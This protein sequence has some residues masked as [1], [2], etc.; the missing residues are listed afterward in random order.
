M[1]MK[2]PSMTSGINTHITMN[3]VPMNNVTMSSLTTTTTTCS[4]TTTTTTAA[5]SAAIS[6]VVN[7]QQFYTP[8]K[9]PVKD[10]PYISKTTPV[11]QQ[12]PGGF[13]PKHADKCA[14]KFAGNNP[15]LT[16]VYTMLGQ[17]TEQNKNILFEVKKIPTLVKS[18]ES[19]KKEMNSR[20]ANLSQRVLVNENEITATK[21][22][23]HNKGLAIDN[24]KHNIN[25]LKEDNKKISEG[26]SNLDA[27]MNEMGDKTVSYDCGMDDD[28]PLKI[29]VDNIKATQGEL[30]SRLGVLEGNG[31][32][33]E[34]LKKKQTNI[35]T[36]LDTLE[37][38]GTGGDSIPADIEQRLAH[39]ENPPKDRINIPADFEHR[40]A[41]L[42]KASKD[43]TTLNHVST[44]GVASNNND[45]NEKKNEEERLKKKLVSFKDAVVTAD[46]LI[47]M[48]SNGKHIDTERIQKNETFQSF[49]CYTFHDV[50]RFFQEATFQV[51]PT[52]LVLHVMTND[53]EAATKDELIAKFK[54][55]LNIARRTLPES[56]FYVSLVLTRKKDDPLNETIVELNKGLVAVCENNLRTQYMNH[57]SITTDYIYDDKHFDSGGLFIFLANLRF[58]LFGLMP[59]AHRQRRGGGQRRAGGRR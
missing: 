5:V 53:V 32:R 4:S 31:D 7:D 34:F 27:R 28:H 30:M 41:R 49:R 6:P 23:I 55:T 20:F 40:I 57:A 37:K 13:T 44:N 21:T 16:N 52:R 24:I 43:R 42:E 10:P 39:L 48:D 51:N 35:L 50:D 54:E 25:K 45:D 46:T 14:Q 11:L 22:L 19:V 59:G 18:V 47:L 2:F 17:L 26:L 38:P 58:A 56:K 29:L 33:V 36:R 1:S 15:A 12:Q 8:P 9:L 3:N